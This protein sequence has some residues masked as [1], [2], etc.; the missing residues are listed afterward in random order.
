MSR[1]WAPCSQSSFKEA[2]ERKDDHKLCF[3]GSGVSCGFEE[4]DWTV[5]FKSKSSYTWTSIFDALIDSTYPLPVSPRVIESSKHGE[6][7]F[8]LK[9]SNERRNQS[10]VP[11]FLR[12]VSICSRKLDKGYSREKNRIGDRICA[13]KNLVG[14]F[15]FDFNDSFS[16]SLDESRS[17]ISVRQ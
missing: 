1:K 12:C 5:S 10:F 7:R 4:V 3:E 14:L 8:P 11:P 13:G 2:I 16:K 15:R 17:S 6:D 9:W